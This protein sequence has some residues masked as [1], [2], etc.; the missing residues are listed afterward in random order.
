MHDHGPGPSTEPS[1]AQR[2]Q[3]VPPSD[4]GAQ[5]EGSH[6]MWWMLVC[7]APMVLIALALILGLLPR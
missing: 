3:P 2:R 6:S 7:C 5:H 4:H 1:T